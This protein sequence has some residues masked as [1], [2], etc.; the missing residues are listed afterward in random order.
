MIEIVAADIGGTH[1]RFAIAAIDGGKVVALGET[2]KLRTAAYDGVQSAWKAFAGMIGRRLP[3]AA[4]I[5]IAAPIAGD[6]L[7]FVNNDWIIRRKSLADDLGLSQLTL[8]NDF[9]AMAYAVNALGSHDM[10]SLCGP[11][12]PLPVDAPVTVIGPG[13]GLGCAILLRRGGRPCVIET[14]AAHIGFAPRWPSEDILLQSMRS[15]YGRVSNERVVSGPGLASL[16]AAHGGSPGHS[17]AELWGAALAGD[18]SLATAALDQF[19]SIFGAVAGDVSLA[20]GALGVA[21]VGGL[22]N[23]IF[24]R[25]G[26]D[27][28]HAA[29]VDKGRYTSRMQSI[30]VKIITHAEP[31][32]FGAASAFAEEH[33]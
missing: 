9:G 16:Y 30:P 22:A 20:H 29:F 10:R 14:E 21:V 28:F 13:T 19:V 32:L 1:A 11:D 4:G 31:G 27:D 18:D 23:R 24:S 3:S 5:G 33:R 15:E 6:E 25:H 26:T 8:V 12:L 17:D 2:V 7:R